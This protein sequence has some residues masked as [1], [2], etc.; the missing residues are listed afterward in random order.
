MHDDGEVKRIEIE[1]AQC[2]SCGAEIIWAN[3]T[4]KDGTPGKMPF[5]K[6]PNEKGY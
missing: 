4:K 6:D 1:T 3:M 2:K 5:D